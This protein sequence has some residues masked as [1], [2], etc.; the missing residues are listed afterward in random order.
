[1]ALRQRK[2]DQS[3]FK[4]DEMKHTLYLK[5]KSAC[6]IFKI[7]FYHQFC[8]LSTTF[9]ANFVYLSRNPMLPLL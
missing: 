2:F 9:V 6:V 7:I 4:I 3:K 8:I 1:M 5:I